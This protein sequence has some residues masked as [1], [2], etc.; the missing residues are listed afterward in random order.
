[1]YRSGGLLSVVKISLVFDMV[2][3]YPVNPQTLNPKTTNPYIYPYMH[4]IYVYL[5][6]YLFDML[7]S[8][9]VNPRPQTF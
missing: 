9:P 3:S 6:T 4:R 8:Y 5:Y 1:M 7:V 2:V